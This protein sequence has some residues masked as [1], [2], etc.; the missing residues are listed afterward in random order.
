MAAN[1]RYMVVGKWYGQRWADADFEVWE[2]Q[3]AARRSLEVRDNMN[4]DAQRT[5]CEAEYGSDFMHIGY[6]EHTAFCADSDNDARYIDVY[7]FDMEYD[8]S[9][10]SWKFLV[11]DPVYRLFLG[12][13]GGVRKENF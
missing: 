6:V 9:L 7:D 2:S 5:L 13:R 12:P 1:K 10:M 4:L 8:E 11:G 3:A